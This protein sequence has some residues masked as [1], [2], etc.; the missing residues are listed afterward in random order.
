MME[1]IL[2]SAAFNAKPH[3]LLTLVHSDPKPVARMIPAI[4]SQLGADSLT[5]LRKLAEQ[6]PRQGMY[7]KSVLSLFPA[8]IKKPNNFKNIPSET[9]DVA[10]LTDS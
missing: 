4:V 5:S 9:K 1:H 6:F 2:I 10:Q 7:F 8:L 3:S